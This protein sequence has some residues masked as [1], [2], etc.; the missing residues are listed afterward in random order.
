MNSASDELLE[1]LWDVY[2]QSPIPTFIS[3][4]AAKIIR[5]N[6]AVAEL[7]GYSPEEATTIDVLIQKLFPDEEYYNNVIKIRNMLLDREINIK[8][9]EFVITRKDGGIR[10]VEVSVYDILSHGLPTD[11]IIVQIIDITDRIEVQKALST[12]EKKYRALF[13]NSRNSV[14]IFTVEPIILDV[15]GTWLGLFGYSGEEIKGLDI[16]DTYFAY[17]EYISVINQLKNNGYI[18]EYEIKRRKKDGTE[19]NCLMSASLQR[20][21]DNEIEYILNIIC[22]ISERKYLE[23]K[24]LQAQKMEAIGTLAAGIAHDFNNILGAIMLNTEL[25]IYDLPKKNQT[26]TLLESVIKSSLRAKNLIE[27]ILTFSRQTG[28]GKRPVNILPIVKETLKLIHATFPSTIRICEHIKSNR[29]VILCDPVQINQIILNLCNNAAYAMKDRG[30][31]LEI[32]MDN[33]MIDNDAI[34][35]YPVLKP[36]PHVRLTVRDTGEGISSSVIERIFEPFYT[37]KKPGE[38]PGMGLSVVHGIIRSYQGEI[39]VHS[40]PGEGSVFDVFLPIVEIEDIHEDKL[41]GKILPGHERILLVDD[42]KDLVHIEK[43]VLEHLGYSVVGKTSSVHALEYFRSNPDWI[44]L[45]ITDLTMPDIDGRELSRA[46]VS[47]RP[48]IPIIL[49]TGYNETIASGETEELGIREIL[50]KP[51]NGGMIAASIRRVLD[52]N[53]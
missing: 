38:G 43:G 47:I 27:Q 35:K 22:D 28:Q 26:R 51:F 30:G 25:A 7:T 21:D 44:D 53:R 2:M 20:S 34:N 32:S 33:V 40:E 12:S 14:E 48:N 50:I 9:D 8:R 11:L 6:D 5:Y 37:T 24:L 13:E 42:E 17:D 39:T 23:N 3:R 19:M 31:T 49:C 52:A 41:L 36:G 45:V 29:D 16:R 46:L 18:K 4:N 15:N 1:L 10:W